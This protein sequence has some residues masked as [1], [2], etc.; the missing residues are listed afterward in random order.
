VIIA[1]GEHAE[2]ETQALL[3]SRR[4]YISI[5]AMT[6]FESLS[7]TVGKLTHALARSLESRLAA[8]PTNP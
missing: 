1:L 8:D 4:S 2:L 3:S 7:E 6:E 5:E